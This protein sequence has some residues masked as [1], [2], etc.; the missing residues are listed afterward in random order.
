MPHMRNVLKIMNQMKRQPFFQS[1]F[2]T[3]NSLL[4]S[5]KIKFSQQKD[6]CLQLIIFIL[7]FFHNIF[8]SHKSL[9][10]SLLTL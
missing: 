4:T 9:W 10:L 5:N 6:V 8:K 7:P 2:N 1:S 3:C